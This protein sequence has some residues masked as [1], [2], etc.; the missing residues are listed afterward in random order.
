MR[1]AI[2]AIGLLFIVYSLFF[3]KGFSFAQQ[4]KVDLYFFYGEGC[5]GCKETENFLAGLKRKY[6]VLRIVS[7]ET[8]YNQ[9]NEALCRSLAESYGLPSDL[10]VPAIFIG[11][12][13]FN[14]WSNIVSIQIEKEVI[15][16]QAQGC[17]SPIEK[18]KTKP[19]P[20]ED[21]KIDPKVIFG[22]LIIILVIGGL[23]FLFVK[24]FLKKNYA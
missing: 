14:S 22:W 5:P 1:K 6:P 15:K 19:L 24:L 17:P 16:C 4:N 18:L 21:S 11:G 20:R 7:F 9:E 10:S 12:R 8:V 3:I 2:L 23:L 13:A